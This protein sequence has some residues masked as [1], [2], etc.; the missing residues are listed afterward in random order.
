MCITSAGRQDE[1]KLRLFYFFLLYLFHKIKRTG[2]TLV[3]LLHGEK[4]SRGESFAKE[5]KRE[6]LGI[7]FREW[8]TESFSREKNFREL[9]VLPI[10]F[11]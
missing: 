1:N 8:T 10:R 7:Y 11:C 3:T 4:L 6:I 9:R 5:K 2:Q